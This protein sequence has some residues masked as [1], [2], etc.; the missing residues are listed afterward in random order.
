L[1]RLHAVQEL[2]AIR[3]H[4]RDD[5]P[6]RRNFMSLLDERLKFMIPTARY[7]QFVLALRRAAIS[8]SA[9]SHSFISF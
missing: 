6:E 9:Y 1:A 4:M 7:Q 2:K 8:L 5:A 3:T